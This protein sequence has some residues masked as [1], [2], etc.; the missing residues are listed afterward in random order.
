MA[1][2]TLQNLRRELASYLG[3]F[4]AVGKDGAAWSTT[5]NVAAST[6]VLS[7]ELRDAGFDDFGEGGSGDDRWENWHILLLGTNN[8]GT[9]R[10]IKN[11]DASAGQVTVTGTNLTAES[12]TTDFELHKHHPN[13]LREALNTARVKAYPALHL[14]ISRTISTTRGQQTYELPSAFVGKPVAI[15]L[16]KP[17]P[18]DTYI[19]NILSNPNFDDFTDADNP[20]DAD[21]WSATTLDTAKETST[22]TPY[23]Y[24]VRGTGSSVRLTSQT[25]NTGTLLQTISSPGTHSGQRISLAIWVYSLTASVVSTAIVNN[26]T[27]NLGTAADA[28]LHKGTGWELLTHYEDM[29]VTVSSLTVGLSVVSTAT[30][31][32][33]FYADDAIAVVGPLM[34]PSPQAREELR[35]WD[36]VPIIEGTSLRNHVIFPY[37]LPDQYLLRI[38]GSGY[39]SE[40]T[41]E[42]DTMEIGSPQTDLLYRYA[43]EEIYERMWQTTPDSDGVFDQRRMQH[44]RNER[45]RMSMHAMTRPNPKIKI[46]N[47]G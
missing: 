39:L 17:Q 38:E 30:D 37:P 3:Y 2:T 44:A 11:S 45:E 25:G 10:R 16:E 23:N 14:P 12:G 28:G 46:P 15:W 34:E 26:G 7:T 32:T 27:T 42:T 5:T 22:T 19:N 24:A 47:W 6:V 20:S 35:R 33:E 4:T 36:Y 13:L 21:S 43:A 41:A 1:T 40:V 9:V 31:N 18:S 8:A 29:P